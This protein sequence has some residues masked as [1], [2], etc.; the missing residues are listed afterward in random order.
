MGHGYVLT[1]VRVDRAHSEC[2]SDRT[3]IRNDVIEGGQCGIII[4]QARL[5][6]EQVSRAALAERPNF[7]G[8]HSGPIIGQPLS[9]GDLGAGGPSRDAASVDRTGR[10]ARDDIPGEVLG[11]AIVGQAPYHT[12]FPS[13]VI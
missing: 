11:I 10:D 12:S 6:E 8:G 2:T 1:C 9:H 7:M 3:L 13:T 5:I 4:K